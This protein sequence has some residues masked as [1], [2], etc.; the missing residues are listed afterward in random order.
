MPFSGATAAIVWLISCMS[1]PS[2]SRSNDTSLGDATKTLIILVGILYDVNQRTSARRSQGIPQPQVR[3][4]GEARHS[5]KLLLKEPDNY[6][7]P[8][9]CSRKTD[10]Q[11]GRK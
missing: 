1:L 10:C 3:Q 11:L 8:N 2:A 7:G 4:A 5:L 6:T 9:G